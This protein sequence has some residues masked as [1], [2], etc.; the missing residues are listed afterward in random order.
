MTAEARTVPVS[1]I[2][3]DAAPPEPIRSLAVPGTWGYAVPLDPTPGTPVEL[4]LAAPAAFEVDVVR[5]GRR[6]IADPEATEADDRT[7]VEVLAEG[8]G[9]EALPGRIAPGSYVWV[10][11]PPVDGPP[12]TLAAWI[13][14]WRLPPLDEVQWGWAGVVS[15]FD[16]PDACRFALLV[17]HAGR[18]AV[19][20]G[21]GPFRHED[22]RLHE[23]G[24]GARLGEWVHLACSFGADAVRLWVD[25]ER[26]GE[27]PA[28][29][30]IGSAGPAAR[31]RLGATAEGGEAAD[32]LD[33]DV[34]QPLVGAFELDDTTARRLAADRGRSDVGGLVDGPLLGAWPLDEEVG[35]RAHDASGSGRDGRIVN[36]ATWQIGGP[37]HD[38]SVGVPGY[39]PA[40]DPDRGHG[41][42]LSSDDLVDCRWPVGFRWDVPPDA[43]SGLYAFRARLVGQAAEDALV[44]PFVV[45]RRTPRRP[46]SVALLCA[47]NT[48]L[49]YGRRPA[50]TARISGLSASF[51][52]THDSGRPFFHVSALAPLPR[53]SAYGFE[54]TR[55][56]RVG[57]SH[58][59]RPE[60]YA[61]AW[62]EREGYAYEVITDFDLHAEP[63]LLERFAALFIAGHNEYWTDAM[64]DGVLGYLRA[65]GAVVS[66]SGNTAW[67]RTS[68]DP[69]GTILES[70]KTTGGDDVRWLGPGRWGERWHS[71]DPGPGGTWQL[72]GAPGYDVLGLD[73]QGMIDDGTPT[74]FTPIDVV[75]PDHPLLHEPEVVPLVD[76][77]IGTRCL[78][79]PQAS[80]YEF[81]A[82]PDHLGL[83]PRQPGLTVLATAVGQRNLEWNGV[84]TDRGADVI[85]WERPDGGRVFAIG[86]IGATGS[87]PV[88]EGVATLT[89]NALARFGVAR[90]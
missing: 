84:E 74:A 65:G 90:R 20:A 18:V 55:A 33:G 32:F 73:T 16:Y 42:R 70:R 83:G 12:L 56:A 44:V 64:R 87:L 17:D 54:S 3:P 75:E 76:G 31:L 24:L 51:Y 46:G 36:G 61:E 72:V 45:A 80:G 27:W 43:D 6:A 11:G 50:A 86:S 34:A 62:L 14:I 38:P 40:A 47:T 63:E 67:W 59:V 48:W 21:D 5:L 2:R 26:V 19:H 1:R 15:D 9:D 81:D 22:L 7:D 30:V 88:D 41:L 57:H 37:A 68:I 28:A 69:S 60:R 53:A 29:A 23:A 66:L 13:R 49:A 79:G 10:D 4:R 78:N 85:W 58:L 39:D 89:R 35:E 52:S 82:T 8:R 77:R 71:E 25:G